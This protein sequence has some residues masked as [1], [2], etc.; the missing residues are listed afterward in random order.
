MLHN[1]KGQWGQ[2]R[3][4]AGRREAWGSSQPHR[5]CPV[6]L[7]TDGQGER[8]FELAVCMWKTFPCSVGIDRITT[9]ISGEEVAKEGREKYTR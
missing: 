1:R 3:V 2:L 8:R 6:S 4:L 7:S 9:G 5:Y